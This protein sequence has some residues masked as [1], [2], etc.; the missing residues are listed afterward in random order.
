MEECRVCYEEMT[1]TYP[2]GG[3]SHSV[4]VNCANLMVER[5]F[6]QY[7]E[8]LETNDETE[9]IYHTMKCYP[10]LYEIKYIYVNSITLRSITLKCPYCRQDDR[11]TYD[12]KKIC[13]IVPSWNVLEDKLEQN[14]NS[15]TMCKE[16]STFAFKV[17]K[18]RSFMRVMWTSVVTRKNVIFC[19]LPTAEKI[20]ISKT[21][22]LISEMMEKKVVHER[23]VPKSVS[24]NY[25]Q[26]KRYTKMIR[27]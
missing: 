6:V 9:S 1:N 18:D 27:L 3:C 22:A 19:H 23:I 20:L 24:R 8:T 13:D 7:F 12:F 26:P 21:K 14:P 2:M 15:F 5:E 10:K 4:C 25:K 11:Q 17:S 16:G